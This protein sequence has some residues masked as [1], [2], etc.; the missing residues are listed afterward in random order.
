MT[1][2]EYLALINQEPTEVKAAD[3]GDYD[4]Q[5]ISHIK[6]EL[7]VV[8]GGDWSFDLDRETVGKGEA[9]AKGT[10]TYRHPVIG[11]YVWRSGTA[12]IVLEKGLR[13]DY[14]KL[15]AAV[16]LNAAKK[17]GKR[18]G[19]DLNKD[20]E[21][22]PVVVETQTEID[23]ELEA[24]TEQLNAAT[25]REEAEDILRKSGF[26]FHQQLKEIVASKQ[27]KIS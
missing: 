16:L 5:P 13:M 27:N 21:D 14:P 6:N 7:D 25:Y 20:R 12:A 1:N 4:F 26:K 11:S 15:E 3:D 10:L 23:P 19:R 24:V 18:F 8:F 22:A 2:E 9:I 17:I